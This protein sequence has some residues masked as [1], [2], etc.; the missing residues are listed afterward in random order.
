MLLERYRGAQGMKT[1]FTCEAGYNLAAT[2]TRDGRTLLAI[3]LG[4]TS[5]NDRAELAARLLNDGF[6]GKT[7]GVD[8]QTLEDF[9]DPGSD[10]GPIDMR[11]CSGTGVDR[12]GFTDSVLGPIVAVADPVKVMTDNPPPPPK[13]PA[14]PP[15]PKVTKTSSTAK[16]ETTKTAA[17]SGKTTTPPKSGTATAA[18]TKG[19]GATAVASNAK[20]PVSTSLPTAQSP[21]VIALPPKPTR[22][23][24]RIRDN[25]DEEKS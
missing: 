22:Q 15:K 8:L 9:A 23:P 17:K 7:P 20:S 12:V 6:A 5:S 19:K 25:D 13:P 1:G 2:A 24:Y 10:S 11:I 4:R 18:T 21:L 14:P 3:V 16:A